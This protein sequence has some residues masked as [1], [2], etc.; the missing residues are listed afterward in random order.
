MFEE[1]EALLEVPS[2]VLL[3]VLLEELV[4]YIPDMPAK[5]WWLTT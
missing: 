4:W 2:E 5:N 3:E 1:L